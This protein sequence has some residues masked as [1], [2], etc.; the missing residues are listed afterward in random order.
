MIKCKHIIHDTERIWSDCARLGSKIVYSIINAWFYFSLQLQLIGI[1]QQMPCKHVFNI[2]SVLF[3]LRWQ[4]S[5]NCQINV[6]EKNI[7]NDFLWKCLY[8][9]RA[10]AVFPVFRLLTDF[11]C[12]LTYELCLS[13]W[14]IARCSVI[15]LLTLFT[16]SMPFTLCSCLSRTFLYSY[17]TG[18]MQNLIKTNERQKHILMVFCQLKSKFF[19]FVIQY[20]S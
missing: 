1:K 7:T 17:E 11:V 20:R 19:W 4:W 8:Q 12:L 15:V 10:I 18:F 6:K 5:Y 3:I 13:L 2:M 16:F 9:F 14:K